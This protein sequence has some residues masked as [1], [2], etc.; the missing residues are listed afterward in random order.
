MENS[1]FGDARRITAENVLTDLYIDL[2]IYLF[3]TKIV[4]MTDTAAARQTVVTLCCA[5]SFKAIKQP[6]KCR[7]NR[8]HEIIETAIHT[9]CK[10]S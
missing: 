10:Q 5:V 3:G 1:N 8:F 4:E 2:Y 7:Q 9:E 6:Q